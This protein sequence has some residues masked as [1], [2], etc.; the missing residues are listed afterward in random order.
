MKW[1]EV[2]GLNTIR[3]DIISD[4]GTL[5]D[6]GHGGNDPGCTFVNGTKEKDYN[7]KLGKAVYAIC[8]QYIKII[9]TRTTDK[10]LDSGPRTNFISKEAKKFKLLNGYSFHVN[11]WNK[12]ANGAEV[13]ISVTQNSSSNDFIWASKFLNYYCKEFNLNKRGIVQR[14]LANGKDYYYLMR[15][16]PSNCRMKI[17][18]LFFGD[19]QK[20]FDKCYNNID[21]IAFFVASYILKRHGIEIE[22]PKTSNIVYKVQA[23]AFEEEAN[24]KNLVDRLK[25]KGF[26]SFIKE[27]KK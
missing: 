16:T 15:D 2:P 22:K 18:E 8:S 26:D 4:E 23:G 27:E 21:K 9:Q 25:Q 20:D 14:K 5:F 3:K 19:N 12:I 1:Y 17:I 7:L 11:A 24:A 13:L 10:T 6:Y